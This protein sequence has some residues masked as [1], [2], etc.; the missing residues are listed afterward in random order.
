[1]C[2]GHSTADNW[3]P[4]VDW[5]GGAAGKA[6]GSDGKEQPVPPRPGEHSGE[7]EE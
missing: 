6:S 7:W 2:A 1:M 4:L 3:P 5:E